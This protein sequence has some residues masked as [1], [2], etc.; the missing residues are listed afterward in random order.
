[1]EVFL[2]HDTKRYRVD[3]LVAEAPTYRLYIAYD[4]EAGK[5]YLLQVAAEVGD[6]S[7]LDRATLILNKLKLNADFMEEDDVE[8]SAK[9]HKPQY[10]RLFP[11]VVDSFQAE[12]Q[13]G[14]RV[15][16]LELK[17]VD[18][19][20]SMA[21]LSNLTARDNKRADLPSSAWIMGRLLK[22]L[23]IV[24]AS[25]ISVNRLG[26]NNVLFQPENHFVV[27]LDWTGAELH[28]DEVTESRRTDDIAKAARAVFTAIG[29]NP[30]TLDYPYATEEG[31]D[32]YV[33]FIRQLIR[34][35]ENDANKAHRRFYRLVRACYGRG[36]RPFNKLPL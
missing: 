12:E 36:F 1:V 33:E 22:L 19:I 26:G 20:R 31:D 35:E 3:E 27:V 25:G 24:H 16:V 21:P 13:E 30:Q 32:Q 11:L 14:R 2:T 5:Q 29:G 28:R 34:G 15:N 6:N 9:K 23:A 4:D 8:A 17:D 7:Q 18:E 10:D